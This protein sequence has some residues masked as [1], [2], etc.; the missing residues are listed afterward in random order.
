MPLV[1]RC[2]TSVP[3]K[4]LCISDPVSGQAMHCFVDNKTVKICFLSDIKNLY[5]GSSVVHKGLI[6]VGVSMRRQ[7][8][9]TSGDPENS[10]M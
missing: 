7:Q 6:E 2:T 8:E 9:Y 3:N 1:G 4:I 5:A 10:C